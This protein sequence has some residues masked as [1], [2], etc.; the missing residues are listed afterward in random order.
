MGGGIVSSKGN[1]PTLRRLTDSSAALINLSIGQGDLLVT[2][3]GICALYAAIVN[4]GEYYL[5]NIVKS[6]TQNG[7]EYVSEW[8]PSTEAMSN[9]TAEILKGFLMSTLKSGTGNKAFVEGVIAGGKTGT[10]QTGWKSDGR[11]I[12]NG[13]FCGFMEG[14]DTDYV[15]VILKEDVKSGSVDCAPIF[16]EITMKMH[17]LGY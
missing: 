5:P 12:L 13:W 7:V 3:I 6:K 4:G 8:L 2:P 17:G 11:S 9:V 14:K 15:I 10:A 1:L 16:G